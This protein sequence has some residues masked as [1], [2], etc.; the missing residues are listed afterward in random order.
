MTRCARHRRRT[1]SRRHAP[2]ASHSWPRKSARPAAAIGAAPSST[3]CC[4]W[5]TPPAETYDVIAPMSYWHARPIAYRYQDAYDYVADSVRLIRERVGRADLPVAVIGQTF[6][7]FS[8]NEIG[9]GNPTGEEVRGAM[10]AARDNGAAGIG[11]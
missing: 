7:W 4:H 11:F 5:R 1:W 9:P 8:R 10:Q 2:T 6:D 3:P